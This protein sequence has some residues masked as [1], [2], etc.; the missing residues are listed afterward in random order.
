M[1]R[2]LCG[3]DYEKRCGKKGGVKLLKRT[4]LLHLETGFV[5]KC[6]ITLTLAWS[7]MRRRGEGGLPPGGVLSLQAKLSWESALPSFLLHCDS[8]KDDE[9]AA[10]LHSPQQG[11]TEVTAPTVDRGREVIR[12]QG[13]K[14]RATNKGKASHKKEAFHFCAYLSFPP[15]SPAHM[16]SPLSP[17]SSPGP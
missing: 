17:P 1:T 14:K 6:S 13:N 7:A 16:T 9:R 2:R 12:A 11:Q 5:G 10:V 4:T 15:S 3:Q 8:W